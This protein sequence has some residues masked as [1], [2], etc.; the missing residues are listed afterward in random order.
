M[1][2]ETRLPERCAREAAMASERPLLCG[3][4][5]PVAGAEDYPDNMHAHEGCRVYH[6]GKDCRLKEA[7]AKLNLEEGT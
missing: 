3:C 1:T 4:P 5:E 7:Q 2:N 6:E